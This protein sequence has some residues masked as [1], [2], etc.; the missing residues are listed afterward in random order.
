MRTVRWPYRDCSTRAV[1]CVHDATRECVLPHR[2]RSGVS[3]ACY[4]NLLRGESI[5]DDDSAPIQV[6]EDERA[7]ATLFVGSTTEPSPGAAL[8][9]S[10]PDFRRLPFAGDGLLIVA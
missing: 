2:R 10:E 1:L 4:A 3:A 9:A 8:L 7:A 5:L 6:L